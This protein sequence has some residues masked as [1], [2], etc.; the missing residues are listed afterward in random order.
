VIPEEVELYKYIGED[1]EAR[2]L[3]EISFVGKD[4]KA[5][6]IEEMIEKAKAIKKD[7]KEGAVTKL[8]LDGTKTDFGP[9]YVMPDG[10]LKAV[11]DVYGNPT[12]VEEHLK[13][14]ETIQK[15]GIGK[16]EFLRQDKLGKERMSLQE[17]LDEMGQTLREHQ[18]ARTKPRQRR[19]IVVNEEG[20]TQYDEIR[21][22]KIEEHTDRRDTIPEEEME[23]SQPFIMQVLVSSDV[24]DG[25]MPGLYTETVVADEVSVEDGETSA[26]GEVY[27]SY[28]NE[29]EETWHNRF[30]RDILK[31]PIPYRQATYCHLD[32]NGFAVKVAGAFM[33]F[34]Y[35]NDEPCE[36]PRD[37]RV[38]SLITG[39]INLNEIKDE[40]VIVFI[41]HEH[42][43]KM[44]NEMFGW[45]N[46]VKGIKYI[47]P[48][49]IY[50]E[51][52]SEG[53]EFESIKDDLDKL[54]KVAKPGKTFPVSGVHV[55]VLQRPEG[56]EYIVE[57]KNA[58]TIY[59]SG[60]LA[61]N[62]CIDLR[63]GHGFVEGAPKTPGI[64]NAK[65]NKLGYK[66]GKL[67]SIDGTYVDEVA[68]DGKP[69]RL[70][71]AIYAGLPSD[72]GLHIWTTH[73]PTQ[74]GAPGASIF[75][76]TREVDGR[77]IGITKKLQDI[78][79][80]EID[81]TKD[82]LTEEKNKI[83]KF[84]RT[85][86]GNNRVKSELEILHVAMRSNSFADK[87]NTYY[88]IW[89]E[90]QNDS[91]RSRGQFFGFMIPGPGSP[92]LNN[93]FGGY[94]AGMSMF[95]AHTGDIIKKYE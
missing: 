11:Q 37:E 90:I 13:F 86:W 80:P 59:H 61:C 22:N 29:P 26:S 46:K 43:S 41:S 21:K 70:S 6:P 84:Y 42:A 44:L 81:V 57:T 77:D 5:I 66:G 49:E 34:D 4:G 71:F 74:E 67:V 2:F 60:A 92:W 23:E 64:I 93:Y 28:E 83:Y 56:V 24:I 82:L 85:L 40:N 89:N 3:G 88:P 50:K 73:S 51:K 47:I 68:V 58:V 76:L 38:R 95:S 15:T 91:G 33:I 17:E 39:V 69:R 53:E 31:K 27:V 62:D 54:I 30:V 75:G 9:G 48:E 25:E 45:R 36:Q 78:Q 55:S 16:D 94:W 10:S 35:T 19:V 32:Y 87:E 72:A 8:Y 63:V 20:W 7:G 79:K 1:G 12:T 14:L 52:I 18:E 65:T